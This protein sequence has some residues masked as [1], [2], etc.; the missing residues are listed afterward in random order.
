M[1]RWFANKFYAIAFIVGAA[2]A[3]AA[4][5]DSFIALIIVRSCVYQCVLDVYFYLFLVGSLFS[6]YE[7]KLHVI[8]KA[9]W[10]HDRNRALGLITW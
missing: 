6:P 8:S 4:A 3:A 7:M 1:P 10:D 2:A 5:A 9:K